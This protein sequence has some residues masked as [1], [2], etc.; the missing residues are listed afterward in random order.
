MNFVK[1]DHAVGFAVAPGDISGRQNFDEAP[2][3]FAEDLILADLTESGK[4]G[5]GPDEELGELEIVIGLFVIVRHQ[6]YLT[7]TGRFPYEASVQPGQ[8]QVGRF[9]IF[10]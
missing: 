3:I 2:I 9:P 4:D 5:V 10:L 8:D 1:A 7:T 6:I